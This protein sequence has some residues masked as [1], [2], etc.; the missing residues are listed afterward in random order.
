MV[1][2]AKPVQ[3]WNF[4]LGNFT[5]SNMTLIKGMVYNS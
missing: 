4:F 2:S 5:M 3:L 1:Q